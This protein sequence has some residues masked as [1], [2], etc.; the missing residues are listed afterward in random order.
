ML[1]ASNG[2]GRSPLFARQPIFDAAGNLAGYELLFRPIEELAEVGDELATAR[3]LLNCF[4]EKTLA[5]AVENTRAYI[6]FSEQWLLQTLPFGTDNVV[7]ELLEGIEV[8]PTLLARVKALHEEGY[9]IALDDFVLNAQ[10]SQLLPYASV[11]KIDVL[12]PRTAD[13]LDAL[14]CKLRR[15]PLKLLAEKVEDYATYERFKAL[16]FDLYQGY[17]FCKPQ[18]IEA[19]VS[20]THR[21]T[22]LDLLHKL[23]DPEIEIAAIEHCLKSDP[24]L[25]VKLL[26]LVNSVQFI[27]SKPA[28]SIRKVIVMLGLDNLKR[29][30][31][32]LALTSMDDKP[33]A[34]LKHA[35]VR[36]RTMENIAQYQLNQRAHCYFFTGLLSYMDAFFDAPLE[37]LIEVLPIEVWMKGAILERDGEVGDLL[38]LMD[39]I[40]RGQWQELAQ[41]SL[42]VSSE[43]FNVA[44]VESIEWVS[45]VMSAL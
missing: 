14:I 37:S 9:Q 45:D 10:T 43:A 2:D 18:L 34:L 12:M 29:W 3:V 31:Y 42:P 7:L 36:A 39:S 23:H 27:Q 30:V 13:E 16:G 41:H 28:D 21:I 1:D 11:V 24:V 44:Y 17:Y 38:T 35:L 33:N 6:N 40:D 22:T 19:K 5:V 32:L 25:A 15:Y 26:K 4:A 20:K 8:T